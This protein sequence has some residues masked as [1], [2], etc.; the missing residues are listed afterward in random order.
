MQMIARAALARA[1]IADRAQNFAGAESA[2]ADHA[3]EV[4]HVRIH[5]QIAEADVLA[6]RVG[7]EIERLVAGAAPHHSVAHRD[8]FVLVRLAAVG[9]VVV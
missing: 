5:V 7:C 1:I 4:Q 6:R 3:G 2:P 9:A 8:D